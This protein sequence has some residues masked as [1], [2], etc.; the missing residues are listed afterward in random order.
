VSETL[1]EAI[2][3]AFPPA[4]Q[5]IFKDRLCFGFV[6]GGFGKGYG[7][8]GH[9]IDMFVAVNELA[10]S[11]REEF[12]SWYI[13]LHEE[14]GLP[15]DLQYPGELVLLQDLECRIR[16]LESSHIRPV[17]ES[18]YEYESILWVDAMSERKLAFVSGPAIDARQLDQLMKRAYSLMLRWRSEVILWRPEPLSDLQKL[19]LRR[20]FKGHVSY[21]KQQPLP[22]G[23]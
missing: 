3:R 9:D 12:V 16:F 5:R 1:N 19:D 14:L 20:L 17:I 11:A 15:P 2:T 8:P 21:L 13:A 10:P 6:F 18:Q 22:P 7:G 4:V 23:I